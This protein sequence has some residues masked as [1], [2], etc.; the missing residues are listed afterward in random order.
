MQYIGLLFTMQKERQLWAA[1]SV[2]RAIHIHSQTNSPQ[3]IFPW[4]FRDCI[5][6]AKYHTLY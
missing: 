2:Q 4:S 1:V 5:N 6:Y 3:F